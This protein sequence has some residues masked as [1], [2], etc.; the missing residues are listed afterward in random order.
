VVSEIEAR[1]VHEGDEFDYQHGYGGTNWVH[2]PEGIPG[3]DWTDVYCT[4]RLVTGREPFES[5]TKEEVLHHR[6][7]YVK[8]WNKNKAW[9]ENEPEMARK[10]VTAKLCRQLPMSV[11]FRMALAVDGHTPRALEPDLA[12]LV[13]LERAAEDVI[14]YADDDPERPFD[15]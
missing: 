9:M 13:A 15:D 14:E 5:M 10:T 3:R 1:I 12:G 4:A 11:E 6:E 8:D 7:R 2:R